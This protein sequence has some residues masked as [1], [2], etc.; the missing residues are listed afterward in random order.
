M[1][2]M[3]IQQQTQELMNKAELIVREAK[4]IVVRDKDSLTAAVDFL[5]RMAIAKKEVDSRRRF[6]K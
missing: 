5:G 4:E 3:T 1:T 2:Q 6:F